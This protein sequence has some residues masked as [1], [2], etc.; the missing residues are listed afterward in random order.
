M[1]DKDT[2]CS[3]DDLEK[4]SGGLDP[5]KVPGGCSEV[6]CSNCHYHNYWAGLHVGTGLEC[7]VCHKHTLEAHNYNIK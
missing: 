2:V 7:P 1:S 3:L 4:V 5:N 6:S